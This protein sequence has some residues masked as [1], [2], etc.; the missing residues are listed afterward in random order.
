MREPEL[1]RKIKTVAASTKSG[2]IVRR[3]IKASVF[4]DLFSQ[5]KYALLLYKTLHPEDLTAKESDVR[6]VTIDN[7]LTDN[8]YNDLGFMV[9]DK[10]LVLAEHQTKWTVNIL[11]RIFLYLAHTWQEFF[12]TFH[13]DLHSVAKVFI[14]RA[15]LYMIYT[16]SRKNRPKRISLNEEFWGDEDYSV[17][18]RVNVLYGGKKSDI[19]SQYVEFTHVCDEQIELYGRTEKAIQEIFRICRERD[20]LTD[21][22]NSR[23]KEIIKIMSKLFSAQ[24]VQDAFLYRLEQENKA[25]LNEAV[26]KAVNKTKLEAA[27]EFAT[28]MIAKGG[29]SLKDIAEYTGLS[30]AAVAKLAKSMS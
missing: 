4:T 17:D 30:V 20:I 23:E 1:P 7:V 15:E 26:N 22:L 10:L 25:K 5:P 24:E 21:Y 27:T 11:P 19:V 16:G 28:K 13:Y 14:P 3:D 29:V 9:R 8:L 2:K 12:K 18:L 6:I